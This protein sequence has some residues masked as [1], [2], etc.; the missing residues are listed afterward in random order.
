LAAP[1]WLATLALGATA[2][3]PDRDP[4]KLEA[5]IFLYAAPAMQ[6]PNFAESVVL[7]V[8]HG[9]G[10]SMGLIVN[11][12][13]RVPLRELLPG[14]D[15]SLTK[16]MR[17]YS[18][19]P[20]QPEAI[21]ALVRTNWPSEQARRVLADV[22]ITGALDDVRAALGAKDPRGTLK[23]FS[24][25]AGWGKGQLESEVR[26]GAW[27]MDRAD[28]RSVFTQDPDLWQR[29]FSILDRLVA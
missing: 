29:V 15:D 12:R 13:T 4:S 10:G 26:A 8:E 22:Y 17:F 18:G 3:E 23:V 24:G 2:G 5:G 25:Y 28:A 14:L 21:L 6:D 19:G 27:V 20:V 11:R 16:E 1:L 9:K 7:L